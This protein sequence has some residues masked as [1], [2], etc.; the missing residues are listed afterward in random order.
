MLQ[1]KKLVKKKTSDHLITELAR[2]ESKSRAMF[3]D[4][5]LFE[6]ILRTLCSRERNR[7]K[8]RRLKDM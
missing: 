3:S 7:P 5:L 6:G 2:V 4:R 1:I 8:K